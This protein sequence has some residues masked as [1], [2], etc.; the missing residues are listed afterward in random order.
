[1]DIPNLSQTQTQVPITRT[2]TVKRSINPIPFII[3]GGIL[4]GFAVSRL[5]PLKNNPSQN[6]QSTTKTDIVSGDDIDTVEVGKVYGN[7][8]AKYN[9]SAIGVIQK[10][11]I[12]GEGTHILVREGGDSQRASLTSSAV[13]LDMFVDKKVEVQGETNASKK[14]SWLH[15]VGTIKIIE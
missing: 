5:A 15:D 6:S 7:A 10:G 2:R 8:N 14:T 1:M 11:S 9:D 12:N 4:V 13:D 3:L